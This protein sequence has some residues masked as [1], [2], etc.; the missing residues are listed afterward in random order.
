MI[1]T[2]KQDESQN[3]TRGNPRDSGFRLDALDENISSGF[4]KPASKY[5]SAQI[6]LHQQPNDL[7]VVQ[8]LQDRTDVVELVKN[9]TP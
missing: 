6:A 4:A 2:P 8:I 1:H 9:Q 3:H 5:L 7:D